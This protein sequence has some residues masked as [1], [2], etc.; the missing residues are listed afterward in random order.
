MNGRPATA[1]RSSTTSAERL[2]HGGLAGTP[3][4][5]SPRVA[6]SSSRGLGRRGRAT[7]SAARPELAAAS[8]W[9]TVSGSSPR[10]TE[11]STGSAARA[12]SRRRR[13]P[14]RVGAADEPVLGRHGDGEAAEQRRRDVVGV[15]LD[16]GGE[17]ED[18]ASSSRVT[19]ASAT[20]ARASTM[21]PTIAADDEPSPRPCGIT[22]TH[23][24]RTAGAATPS[25]SNAARIERCTRCRSSRGTRAAPSPVTSI[26][27]RSVDH[28]SRQR[29]AQVQ[30]EPEAVEAGAEVGAGRRHRDGDR[31][32]STEGHRQPGA[33]PRPRRR[34]RRRRRCRRGR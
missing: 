26:V 12:R 7:S 31:P 21:P 27:Q 1:S 11:V 14:R 30:G 28:L 33:P 18:A 15:P 34:R 10:A 13:G 5:G 32:A 23:G 4:A 19:P 24:R 22:L 20:R 16:L 8:A 9:A 25:A 6:A 29:V 17:R 2:R 3:G